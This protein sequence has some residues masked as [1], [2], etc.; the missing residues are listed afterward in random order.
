MR[1]KPANPT[2]KAGAGCTETL[3]E[4]DYTHQ[5][6]QRSKTPTHLILV[7]RP[8]DEAALRAV[9]LDH[10]ELGQDGRDGGNDARGPD[11]LVQV[12]LAQIPE[13]YKC[14]FTLCVNSESSN[15]KETELI[16]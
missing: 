14:I 8:K 7:E 6:N 11:E 12:N 15:S 2:K 1:K 13:W 16:N 5:P 4:H 3:P 9:E 10:E